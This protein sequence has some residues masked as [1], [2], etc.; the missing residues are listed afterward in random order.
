MTLELLEP[1]FLGT[2]QKCLFL[3]L[4][5]NLECNIHPAP[6]ILFSHNSLQ[7]TLCFGCIKSRIKESCLFAVRRFQTC[8][9]P[10]GVDEVLEHE[11]RDVDGESR[12]GIVER[13]VFSEDFVLVSDRS[14]GNAAELGSGGS[15]D[16]EVV[17]YD[18]DGDTRGAEVLLRTGIDDGV[19][20]NVGD[21][22]GD[23]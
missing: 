18:K 23:E 12:R 7:L 11:G 8:K 9:T 2:I 3:T 14:C 15:V 5:H 13:S 19:F 1:P 21:G 17:P 16:Q 6:R 22:A 4:S 10:L 20:L